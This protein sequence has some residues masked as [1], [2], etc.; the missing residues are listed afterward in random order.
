MNK[1]YQVGIIGLGVVGERVLKQFIDHP[2]FKVT[3][4]CEPNEQ[5]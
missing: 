4:Y 3:D 2:R 5:S 1:V